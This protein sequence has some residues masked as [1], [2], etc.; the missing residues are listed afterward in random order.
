[1][2]GKAAEA[3]ATLEGRI[4]ILREVLD[5]IPVPGFEG[6]IDVEV[7]AIVAGDTLI[8]EV[9]ALIRPRKPDWEIVRLA[10]ELPGRTALEARGRL[11]SGEAFGFHG[12]LLVASRQ[13]SGFAAWAAGRV[14]PAFRRLESAGL[15]A[16]VTFTQSQLSFEDMELRPWRQCARRPVSAHRACRCKRSSVR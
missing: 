8:R 16:N 3:A 4:A 10:A 5:Q 9:S 12:S 7:P 1:M 15:D 2:R 6:E 11:G 13:P 14:D